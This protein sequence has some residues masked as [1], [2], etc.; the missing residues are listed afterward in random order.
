MLKRS[1]SKQLKIAQKKYYRTSQSSSA[2]FLLIGLIFVSTIVT[3]KNNSQ[4]TYNKSKIDELFSFDNL[5]R[6]S[7]SKKMEVDNN[8]KQILKVGSI[9][10]LKN[11]DFNRIDNYASSV[12]YDGTSVF[13]LASLLSPYTKTEAEKARIIY[14]WITYNIAYDVSAYLS[15]NYGDLSP[16]EILKTRKGVCS[17]FANLYEA[18]A[19]AMGLDVAV[20]DGYAKGYGYVVGNTTEINHAWNAVQINHKWYLLDSTWGAG[21]VNSGQFNQQFNPYYFATPPQQFIL[22]HFPTKR[23]WQLLETEYTKQQFETTPEISP[24]FFK[25][26]L[27]LVSHHHHT[28]ETGGRFQVVLS[29]PEDTIALAK[30]KSNWASFNDAYTLVQKRDNK[31][32]VNVAPPVGNSQLEIFSRNKDASGAYQQAITYKVI[33]QNAGE[34]FPKTYSTFLEKNSYLSSPLNKSLP[35]NQLAYF[36]IE[37]PNALDVQVIDVSSNK[38]IKLTRSGDV[39]TGNVLVS[40]NKIQVSAKF[41]GDDNYWTLVEYN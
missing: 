38:W 10:E 5:D 15:G 40:S 7:I 24:E 11:T 34:E 9:D 28:I 2:F 41:L 18:L 21:N 12:R 26:G 37:V 17:G 13:E 4:F 6:N 29:A 19:K 3:L 31:I 36:Q 30:L 16:P 23:E 32:I 22:D 20:V 39:F 33:S 27:Q 1:K 14:S 25:D 35:V 8:H